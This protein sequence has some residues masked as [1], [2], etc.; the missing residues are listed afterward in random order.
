MCHGRCLRAMSGFVL[1]FRPPSHSKEQE[2]CS[3][4]K[5]QTFTVRFHPLA[6]GSLRLV[7]NIFGRVDTVSCLSVS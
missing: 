3:I 5:Y 2:W 6:L 4:R 1:R 7:R